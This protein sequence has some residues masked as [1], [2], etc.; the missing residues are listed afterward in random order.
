MPLL[1]HFHAP[2]YPRE[3]WVSF[4]ATWA[5]S[6]M[7]QLNRTTSKRFRAT[8]HIHLG[9]DVE[10]DVAEFDRAPNAADTNGHGGG[11]ATATYAPP[12]VVRSVP[13]LFPDDIEVRVNDLR[14]GMV[15]VAVVEL[16]SPANKHRPEERQAFAA[17]CSAYLRRGLG[18]VIVDTVTSRH[19]NLH[20]DLM[21][22]LGHP[23]PADLGGE[24][25]YASAYRPKHHDGENRIDLW[26]N[27]LVVGEG[28]PTL[29]LA[30]RGYG[31]VPLDLEAAYIDACER[32]GLP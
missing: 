15:V 27:R 3:P 17:K 29:P 30:L 23:D 19:A 8:I 6:I 21:T 31:F 11:V 14:D 12:A 25:I 5:S 2:L 18:L 20:D 26:P 4:H 24:L 22:L 16:V 13:A 28:L 1:D 10:A 32:S 7:A 9:R